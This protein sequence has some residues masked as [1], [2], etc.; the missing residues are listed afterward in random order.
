[1]YHVMNVKSLGTA[2]IN[3]MMSFV[4]MSFAAFAAFVILS[5][6]TTPTYSSIE[7]KKFWAGLEGEF[8]VPPINTN[9][10]GIA[11]F[12]DSQDNIWY[13]INVTNIDNITAA[14]LHSGNFGENGPVLASLVN[15]DT[16]TENVSETL[17][18]GNLTANMLEGPLLGKQ[19]SDLVLEMQN[20]ATYINIHTADYP[21]GEI[22]GQIMS[23]DSTHAEIM[24]S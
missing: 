23:A 8:E 13:M 18:Q 15:S 21:D 17:A 1:M 6:V 7:E 3:F 24:M 9:A 20:N 10:S 16:P 11:M 14:H 22:R 12:K 5:S 2:S 19:L 4:N